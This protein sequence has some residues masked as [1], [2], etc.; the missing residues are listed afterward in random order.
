MSFI[1]IVEDDRGVREGIA[2]LLED[3]GYQ[4]EAVAGGRAAL[5]LMKERVPSLLLLDLMMPEMTGW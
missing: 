4:V 3:E 5:A 1:L 2:I